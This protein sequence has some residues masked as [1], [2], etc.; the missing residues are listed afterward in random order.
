MRFRFRCPECGFVLPF[1]AHLCRYQV[2]KS[3]FT[4]YRYQCPRCGVVSRQA[5]LWP[6]ALWAWPL[7]VAGTVLFV[8]LARTV[9]ACREL[10]SSHPGIYGLLGGL[11]IIPFLVG[12]LQGMKLAPV[13]PEEETKR[14][15]R[16]KAIVFAAVAVVCVV[17]AGILLDKW[18]ESLVLAAAFI[19]VQLLLF[20]YSR[21]LRSKHEGR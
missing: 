18:I 5:I 15:A 3:F 11:G 16:G 13:R 21:M 9:P 4:G 2:R 10:H 1:F 7:G 17:G 20:L 12:I 14:E 6:D 8:Y 19:A